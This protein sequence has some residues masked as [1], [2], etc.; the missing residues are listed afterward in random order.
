[1]PEPKK[2]ESTVMG[3]GRTAEEGD[4][5]D[6]DNDADDNDNADFDDGRRCRGSSKEKPRANVRTENSNTK[7]WRILLPSATIVMEIN[8]RFS[9]LLETWGLSTSSTR[10]PKLQGVVAFYF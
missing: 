8:H 9:S 6:D 10:T 7:K 3:I 2:P 1:L 5:D 4:D